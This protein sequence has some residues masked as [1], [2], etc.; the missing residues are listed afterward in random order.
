MSSGYISSR[1]MKEI[2]SFYERTVDDLGLTASSSNMRLFSSL[3]ECPNCGTVAEGM[4]DTSDDYWFKEED[5]DVIMKCYDCGGRIKIEGSYFAD[6]IR[7][8]LRGQPLDRPYTARLTRNP[9]KPPKMET[10]KPIKENI[11]EK[12]E[13]DN[14]NNFVKGFDF[15]V[16]KNTDGIK[17]CPF[18][19]AI[20]NKQGTYVAY[21]EN[22]ITDVD[23]F[24]MDLE[25]MIYKMPV[26]RDAIKAGDVIL[27]NGVPMIV[28]NAGTNPTVVDPVAGEIKTIMP[29]KNLF[30]FNFL[31]KIVS[32][33]D[34]SG[35]Q[36][37]E[38]NPF[39][40]LLPLMLMK[41]GTD[42]KGLM[43]AMMMGQ[44]GGNNTFANPMMMMALM[45]DKKENDLLPLLMMNQCFAPKKED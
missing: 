28:T 14:M 18:G 34:M 17:F 26:S 40:N 43:M 39:G 16:V 30:G 19:L 38:N 45:G 42:N 8:E 33:I 5:I 6:L 35:F 11:K 2:V 37:N 29:T 25:G 21:V 41:D 15:G 44:Q 10:R 13:N 1:R 36:A 23:L 9:I 12:K 4:V 31:T 24:D 27:H 7:A 22:E 3:G 20:K 32:L